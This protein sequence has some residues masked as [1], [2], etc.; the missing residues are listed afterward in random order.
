MADGITSSSARLGGGGIVKLVEQRKRGSP[1][2]RSQAIEASPVAL[3]GRTKRF[4]E[5]SPVLCD[6]GFDEEFEGFCR[7][8]VRDAFSENRD[9]CG[10]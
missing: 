8:V 2:F 4:V 7:Q 9:P 10:E 3:G 6:A 5:R 1:H